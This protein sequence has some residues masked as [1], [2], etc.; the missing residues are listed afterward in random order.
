MLDAETFSTGKSDC[1][2]VIAAMTFDEQ[3]RQCLRQ[4]LHRAAHTGQSVI[5]LHIVHETG[6]TSGMYRR[7][8]RGEVLRPDVDV[9]SRLLEDFTAEVLSGEPA[10]AGLT[11]RQLAVPGIPEQR[12][13]D[14][15]RLTGADL[16][17]IGSRPKHGLD[18]LFGRNVTGA[19]LACAPC[20]VLV[21]DDDGD[22]VDPQTLTGRRGSGPL[23]RPLHMR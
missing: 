10:G 23:A 15:A 4:A 21:I 9:A 16:I 13:P 19:V 17:V 3:G 6:R 14:V 2:P 1:G 20:P 8:D 22:P 5:A 7:H 12:I 18:R 11:L